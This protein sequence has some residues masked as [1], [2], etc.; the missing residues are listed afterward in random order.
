MRIAL[1]S[2]N[3][4][5]P[6]GLQV[7]LVLAS[8]PAAEKP[9]EVQ[10]FHKRMLTACDGSRHRT[11]LHI[12]SR[13]CRRPGR[14]LVKG[15][16]LRKRPKPILSVSQTETDAISTTQEDVEAAGGSESSARSQ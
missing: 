14:M 4:Y 3:G 9:C 16:A 5:K 13:T 12:H 8:R 7:Q 2:L 1:A 11:L 6:H 10:P 15:A